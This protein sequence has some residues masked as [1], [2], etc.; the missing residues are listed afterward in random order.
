MTQHGAVELKDKTGLTFLV[1][2]QRVKHYFGEDLDCDRE[3][4]ELNDE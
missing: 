2:G 4:L 1:N 3:A